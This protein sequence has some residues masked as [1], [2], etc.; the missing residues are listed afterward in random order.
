MADDL[1]ALPPYRR[2]AAQIRARIERGELRPG[3]RVPSVREIMR[4][5]SVTTATATRVAAVL[6]A[7]G[8]AQSIPGVGT[9]VAKPKRLTSGPDRLTI[10]R[11]TGSGFRGGERVEIVGAGLIQAPARVADALGVEEGSDVAKRSRVYRDDT[12]P[13]AHSTSWLPAEIAEF[14]PELL[15][16]EPLPSMTFGLVE[17]R[18]GR[19]AVRRRDVIALRPVP[20]ELA[21][22]VGAPAGQLVLTMTNT[23]WDQ[24]GNPTEYAEDFLGNGRELSAEYDLD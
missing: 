23:Y 10:L 8:F 19:R 7:D 16:P 18:T 22:E 13:I 20:D 15:V 1:A 24:D 21:D 3:D 11:A 17:E 2:I 12:G 6:R 5:E 4:T 9:I 14:A